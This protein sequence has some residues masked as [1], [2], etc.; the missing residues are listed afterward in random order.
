MNNNRTDCELDNRG[1]TLL[2]VIIALSI[3]IIILQVI[4]SIFFIGNNSFNMTKNKGFVQ[5]DVRMAANYITRE[6][7]NAKEIQI[8]NFT[9][10]DLIYYGFS[11]EEK[12][13]HRTLC[14]TT[15]KPNKTEKVYVGESITEL[16]FLPLQ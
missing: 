12:N 10:K 5:N 11:L 2:E 13:G 14:R 1:I 4:Y 7:R 9:S 15:Y 16:S 8:E 3:M 6:I